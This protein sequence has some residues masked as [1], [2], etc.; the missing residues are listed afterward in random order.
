[1]AMERPDTTFYLL[2]IAMF[3]LAVAV[4]EIITYQLAN[5]LDAFVC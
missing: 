3:V 1:M 2:A 4:C 5:V